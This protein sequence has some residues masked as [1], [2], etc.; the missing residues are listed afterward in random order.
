MCS[1]NCGI[2]HR[3]MDRCM[4]WQMGLT[5]SPN[6]GVPQNLLVY[7]LATHF[8]NPPYNLLVGLASGFEYDWLYMGWCFPQLDSF[9][10]FWMVGVSACWPCVWDLAHPADMCMT[11]A[12]CTQPFGS[13]FK[14]FQTGAH[15]AYPK[16]ISIGFNKRICRHS[17]IERH[18]FPYM[19]G[20]S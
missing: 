9:Y 20:Y 11:G 5:V 15:V 2:L 13:H 14:S 10:E 8:K 18:S 12:R 17:W 4:T 6:S 3:Y 19:A 1:G 16:T 7:S